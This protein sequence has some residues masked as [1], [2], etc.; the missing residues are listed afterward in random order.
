MYYVVLKYVHKSFL[1]RED[2]ILPFTCELDLVAH[3]LT[4]E[5]CRNENEVSETRS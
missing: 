4:L 3:F 1:S 5:Y 2:L